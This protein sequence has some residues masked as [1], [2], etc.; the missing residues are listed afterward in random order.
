MNYAFHIDAGLYAKFL[1]KFAEG[2]GVK[3]IEGKIVDV[4][5]DET[6]GNIASIKLDSGDR[7][8]R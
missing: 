5:V 4:K 2:F 8:R 7:A 3:R 1:R 6:S